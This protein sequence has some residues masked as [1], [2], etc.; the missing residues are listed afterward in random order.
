MAQLTDIAIRNLRPKAG[1]KAWE[2]PDG[3]GLYIL[4]GVTGAKSFVMR[5]RR[6]GRPAKLTL[7][8][9][10]PPEER[11]ATPPTDVRIGDLMTLA[12]ARKLAADIK[13]QLNRGHDPAAVKRDDAQAKQQ[14]A[15]NTFRAVAERYFTEVCGMRV[16]ADGAVI[17]N[18]E[19]KRSAS[20]Q[21]RTLKRQVFATLGD[22][23]L[24][25][26]TK[27]DI[28]EWLDKL[29]KGKLRNDEGQIIE[30]GPV[31]ANRALAAVRAI[32]LWREE[33][34][35]VYRAPSFRGLTRDEK[36]RERSLNDDELRVI[37]KVASETTGPFGLFLKFL[38]L[39]ASRRTE[40]SA[41][42][43]SEVTEIISKRNHGTEVI[44]TLP[45]S[46]N[47]AGKDLVRPL[48][49][50]AIVVLNELPNIGKFFFTTDGATP[51]SAYALWKRQFDERVLA[52]LR[53]T[54]PKAE[55]LPHFQLHDFRRTARSLLSRAGVSP[56]VAEQCLG[57]LV[58]GIRGV[59]D[60]HDFLQEKHEAFEALAALIERIVTPTDTVVAFRKV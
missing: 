11:P 47:K 46:R 23:P 25:A 42:T 26:I 50:A 57:H 32:L 15:E 34:S 30:G 36:A 60:K 19:R 53:R 54:D 7:G 16:D 49:K 13:L 24:D 43:R 6:D 28:R 18:R 55:P 41:M 20:E 4:V 56:D 2:K 1:P 27:A 33:Q 45:A 35:D 38:L 29:A 10:L 14:A 12:T 40:A 59:Y 37:W 9:W 3:R 17:F 58:T 44:W 8:K 31:A 51:I 52:E 39:T 21:W 48:S 22:R 5:Y